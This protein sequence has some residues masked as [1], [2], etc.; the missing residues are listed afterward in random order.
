VVRH[1]WR[2]STFNPVIIK[3][4]GKSKRII[5]ALLLSNKQMAATLDIYT[6]YHLT[7]EEKIETD[8]SHPKIKQR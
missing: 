5:Q 6:E 7:K 4:N 2:R 1:N 8:I 3:I